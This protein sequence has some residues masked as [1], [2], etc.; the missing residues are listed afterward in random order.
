MRGGNLQH[1]RP[2][3]GG[4]PAL[5]RSIC[6]RAGGLKKTLSVAVHNHF[7]TR[8]FT[9]NCAASGFLGGF[10]SRS[11]RGGIEKSNILLIVTRPAQAKRCSRKRWPDLLDVPFF[12]LRMRPPLMTEA[13]YVGEDVERTS[14]CACSRTR[15]TTW[16]AEIGIVYID[17]ID[18]I[19]RKTDNVSITRAT[20]R[21]KVCNK[22]Y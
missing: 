20:S 16:R 5:A 15:I 10:F 1:P 3:T 8:D 7:Q 9:A 6:D 17:E 2:E 11:V 14:S 12:A 22:L 18:K 13:G 4:Y 21:A 19:G